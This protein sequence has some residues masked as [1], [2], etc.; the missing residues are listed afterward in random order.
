MNI[1]MIM[2]VL[3]A[4]VILYIGFIPRITGI[5]FRRG[6]IKD[7]PKNIHLGNMGY[8]LAIGD[9]TA[10]EK[11]LYEH[12]QYKVREELEKLKLQSS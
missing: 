2:I 4:L 11:E 9:D 5:I 7:N 10:A 12:L 3:F 8:F 1:E 6:C